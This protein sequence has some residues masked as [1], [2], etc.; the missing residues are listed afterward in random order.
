MFLHSHFSYAQTTCPIGEIDCNG[1]CAPENWVEITTAMM[2]PMNIMVMPYILIVKN[3]SVIW[4]IAFVM[5]LVLILKLLPG[6]HSDGA[7]LAEIIR[8]CDWISN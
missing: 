7:S 1:N 4:V 6:L 5:E 2:E 8:E 3:L